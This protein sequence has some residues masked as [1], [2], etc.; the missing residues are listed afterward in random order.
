MAAPLVSAT[1]WYANTAEAMA[2]PATCDTCRAAIT[3]ADRTDPHVR[4]NEDGTLI[5]WVCESCYR[6]EM[7]TPDDLP[8]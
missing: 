1:I 3:E 8:Y 7:A 5:Y 6:R 2:R 4:F